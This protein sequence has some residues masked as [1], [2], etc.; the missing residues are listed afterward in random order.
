[1]PDPAE[2]R[3]GARGWMPLL[4]LLVLVAPQALRTAGALRDSDVWWHLATGDWIRRHGIPRTDPFSWT[5]AGADWQPNAWLADWLMSLGRDTL[6][7][8]ALSIGRGVVV[9]IVAAGI[10]FRC[11]DH[12]VTSSG[13]VATA[14]ILTLALSPFIVER[15]AALSMVL[16]V[17]ALALVER[18]PTTRRLVAFGVL[19]AA[20]SNLHGSAVVGV[21]VAG[22]AIAGAALADRAALA[23]LAYAA[24]GAVALLANPYGWGVYTTFFTV[25]SASSTIDE[26]QP[27]ALDDPRGVAFALVIAA[28]ALVALARR[29]RRDLP[30]VLPT[31]A[32]AIGTLMTVRTAA[33]LVV[34]ASPL[35]GHGIAWLG[36]RL[37]SARYADRPHPGV[38]AAFGASI[39][40]AI[41]AASTVGEA[42]EIDPAYSE[43]LVE[44]LPA[45]CRLFNDYTLGGWVIDR[46]HPDVL[47]SQDGRNDLYGAAE[48]A[49]QT[50]IVL[51]DD[52]APLDDLEV[53]CVYLP[54]ARR[55][56][57]ALDS[58]PRWQI[59]GD[60][61]GAAVWIRRPAV[62]P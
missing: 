16:V 21:G 61:G 14:A 59:A 5:A 39:V 35:V 54:R 10:W 6:G 52:P 2:A 34:V 43:E 15:P 44:A 41:A 3:S 50:A 8:T 24:V 26:W 60:E 37:R 25:R 31:A 51:G 9:P 18:D 36:G 48:I 28:A 46:R 62:S 22:A 42:G 56:A 7:L 4:A 53:D 13:S 11:R 45:G 38:V 17:P 49:R 1:M 19:I 29:H 27:L 12:R 55:L 58:D 57:T 30:V 20:W 47:V 33:L 32:L 23:R 40:L